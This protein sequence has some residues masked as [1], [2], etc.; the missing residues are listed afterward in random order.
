MSEEYLAEGHNQL[1]QVLETRRRL[2]GAVHIA[3]GEV[4]FTLGL[5]ELYLLG[6]DEAAEAFVVAAHKSYESQLG[7][8]H[9]SAMHVTACLELIV[10]RIAA[11]DIA[12]TGGPMHGR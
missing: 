5:F 10:N 3:T 6:N 12:Q 2:L 11:N 4:Q 7:P 8:D 9:P 1:E